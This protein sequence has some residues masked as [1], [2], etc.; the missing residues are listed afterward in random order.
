MGKSQS[1]AILFELLRSY[2][3]LARTLNLSKAVRELG[4]TRQT[5]RRH[6][7]LLEESM[8]EA[9]FTLED[10]QYHLTETGH[11]SLQEAEELLA[12]GKAWLENQSKHVNE[13]FHLMYEDESSFSYYLQQHPLGRLWADGTPL[14]QHGF[15]CWAK[16]EGAIES[17]AFS[18]IR[19]YL[20]IFRRLEQDWICVEVG[21]ESSYATWYGWQ[22]ERSSVG[23]GIAN[24]PGGPGFANLLAQPFQDIRTRGGVRLDHIHTQIA[25]KE[26]KEMVPISYQRLLMGCRFPDGSFALAALIDRTHNIDI[27]GLSRKKA[28]SMP[29]KFIMNAK[30]SA[31]NS[32]Q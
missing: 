17:E 24:L 27:S 11:R 2:T 15:Q 29:S 13:L 23:R 5:V 4:S 3:T 14:L 30:I 16:A 1:Q 28:T 32:R 7:H 8:G 6:I 26:G 10:R 31:L 9:L 19:P 18:V 21:S 20:M 12:R 25:D 22:W